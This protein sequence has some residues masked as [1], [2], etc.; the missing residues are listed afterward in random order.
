MSLKPHETSPNVK[1]RDA[2]DCVPQNNNEEGGGEGGHGLYKPTTVSLRMT[3][4]KRFFNFVPTSMGFC[5]I[6]VIGHQP[7]VFNDIFF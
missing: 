5:S 3:V 2:W 6:I 4:W 1:N 7:V